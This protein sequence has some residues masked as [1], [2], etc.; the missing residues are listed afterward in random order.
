[1]PPGSSSIGRRP[2]RQSGT[3]RTATYRRGLSYSAG[4]LGHSR[5]ADRWR[6]RRDVEG[7]LGAMQTAD[8]QKM[9]AAHGA[10]MSD[11]RLPIEPVQWH[12]T[13]LIQ[14]RVLVHGED[15]STGRNYLM[16]EGTDRNISLRPLH[17]GDRA[18]S[19][20]RPTSDEFVCSLTPLVHRRCTFGSNGRCRAS[21]RPPEHRQHLNQ[22][23]RHLIKRKIIPVEDGWG[24]WLD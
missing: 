15:D 3:L 19:E 24:R 9:L 6:V 18:G 5:P 20:R 14:G 11:E 17:A 7:V 10:L 1:M 4:W 13:S 23:A 21:R 2:A 22:A 8:R 16:R 12:Q